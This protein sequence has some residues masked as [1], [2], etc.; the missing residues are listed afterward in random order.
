VRGY[1]L[2]IMAVIKK[3][4][5]P[6][7]FEDIL[8]GKKKFEFRVADFNLNEGD[9]LIL[10]EFDPKTG[11]YTGRSITKKVGYIKKF[12]LNEFNNRELIEKHGFYV[13]QLE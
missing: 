11:K 10:E 5:W 8:N 2:I 1:N 4:T 7:L 9:E 12:L 13:I 6:D 3:K